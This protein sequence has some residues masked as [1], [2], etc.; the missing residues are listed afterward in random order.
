MNLRTWFSLISSLVFGIIFAIAAA[1]IFLSF[2]SSTQRNII[3]NLQKTCLISGVYY[4]EKD[5]QTIKE[6]NEVKVQFEELIDRSMVAVI[7]MEDRIQFGQLRKDENLTKG[8]IQ[9]IRSVKKHSFQSKNHFYYGMFYKDNQGDFVVIVKE[10]K[11]EYHQL[12]DRLLIVLVLTLLFAWISIAVLSI[13]LSKIAYRPL[14]RVMAEINRRTLENLAEPIPYPK[15]EDEVQKLVE[16]YN[17]LLQRVNHVFEAQKNFIDYVSHEFK[18]PLTA[19]SVALEV[20]SQKERRPE[21]YQ[22]VSREAL[23]NVYELEKILSN[24]KLLSGM[25]ENYISHEWIRVDELVWDL[26]ERCKKLYQANF[27]IDI[28]VADYKKLE[29]KAHETQLNM[30]V[31]NILENAVKYSDNQTVDITLREEGE[32]IIL[33]I[34]DY[35]QGIQSAD[36]PHIK[37]PFYRS[38]KV[39]NI[40]G[41]GVGL[42]LAQ[43]ILREHNIGFDIVSQEKGTL[44]SLVFKT[45]LSESKDEV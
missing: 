1:I 18:T 11:E 20:Y 27:T 19:I 4:L 41:S 38:E 43:I 32:N 45:S 24:M 30:A 33:L 37:K 25:K 17:H 8:K 35:G 7:D 42:S 9:R 14:Q 28:Q 5:E 31:F 13:V 22:K 40:A 39:K 3:N 21:E 16:T 15:G 44:V 2:R 36:F 6:H 29:Y 10:S 12:V 23:Q 26:T 34:Q